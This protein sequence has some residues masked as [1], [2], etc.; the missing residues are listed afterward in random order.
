MTYYRRAGDIPR[1]RHTVFRDANGDRLFEELMGTHGFSG[2]SSL[3]YHRRSPSAL[4]GIDTTPDVSALSR[5]NFP[6]SPLHFLTNN[7][8]VGD[9]VVSSRVVLLANKDVSLSLAGG[10]SPS[11]LFR[12]AIG[13]QVV[14][15]HQGHARF[16]SI[17]GALDVGPG[18][19][20]V[21][22]TSTTH[23]W[24]PTSSEPLR[25]FVI[26][27]A[28]H[29]GLPAKY[30]TPTGQLLEGA[31]YCERDLRAPSEPLVVDDAEL[32]QPTDVI[33]QTRSGRTVLHNATHPFD[34]VGWDG[35]LYPYALSI[36]DFEPIVGSLHQ[37]PPVHQTFAGPGFVICSFVPRLLDFHPD[38][39][40]I[41]Y[42]H[43]NVDSDEVLFYADGDFTSRA[44]SGVAV[45]SI[46]LH[47]AGFVHGPQPGSWEAS[48]D[49]VR[50]DELAVMV[51]TFA[52]L[53]VSDDA[54]AV[55]AQD[56]PTSWSRKN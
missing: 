37:P 51:D 10:A 23:R 27:A 4:V 9:D 56:Y 17:F 47:P 54:H 34:V 39:V 25:C 3:L 30:L 29:I 28:G 52:P 2:A 26:A 36:H 22:P 1:K 44:G 18:D 45:G 15:V 13:D 16:E 8:D 20:V 48:V 24:V 5:A 53:L 43:A 31:P 11:P 14:F 50:T 46:T 7:I 35:A 12:D 40:K 38:A 55:T 32:E 6:L 42:H 41:P 33:V 19:Y 49:A 21:I